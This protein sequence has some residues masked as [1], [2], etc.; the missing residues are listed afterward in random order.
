MM[1]NTRAEQRVGLLY[2]LSIA[3]FL[4]IGGGCSR[5]PFQIVKV[6]TWFITVILRKLESNH[7]WLTE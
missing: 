1:Q 4:T 5:N 2:H 3:C 7:A 6:R